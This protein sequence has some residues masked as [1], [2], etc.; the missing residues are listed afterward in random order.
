MLQQISARRAGF[1]E[2]C[3]TAQAYRGGMP[4]SGGGGTDPFWQGGSSSG[5]GSFVVSTGPPELVT[6]CTE[7]QHIWLSCR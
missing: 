7:L 4:P 5:G 2:A 3:S 1:A 6:R